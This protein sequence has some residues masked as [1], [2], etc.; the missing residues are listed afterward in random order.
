MSQYDPKLFRFYIDIYV[1]VSFCGNKLGTFNAW[2]LEFGMLFTHL[3]S[4]PRVRLG[5]EL[6][7][8]S[9][10]VFEK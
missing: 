9:D 4:C 8:K 6:Y 2:K 7:N 1:H 3:G 5:F 10:W